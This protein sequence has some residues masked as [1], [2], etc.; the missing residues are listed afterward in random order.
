MPD[1]KEEKFKCG[2]CGIEIGGHNQYCHDGMCDD[3]Y[4]EEYFP[5]DAQVFEADIEKIKIHCRMGAIKK[6]NQKF[7]EFLQSA[8]FDQERVI[9]IIK[10]IEDKIKCPN[11]GHCCSM[12]KE[13]LQK[14]YLG[15]FFANAEICPIV[16]NV[17]ENAKE[18][19]LENIYAFENHDL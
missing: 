3:C 16:F 13:G 19:F 18:D 12:L 2:K 8:D 4:F 10:E 15:K 5:E 17:L 7:K 11:G 6:E 1:T 14:K 9:K